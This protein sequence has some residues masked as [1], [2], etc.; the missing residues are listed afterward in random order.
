MMR[1]MSW[2]GK[3]TSSPPWYVAGLAFECTGCG[4]C[5]A[6]PA[7]GYVWVSDDEVIAIARKLGMSEGA[8]RKQYVRKVGRRFS[9]VEA[10]NRDCIFLQPAKDGVRGCGIYEVRPGQCRTWPFWQSNLGSPEAWSL[11]A[12]RCPGINRGPI[13]PFDEI[14]GKR[15][16]TRE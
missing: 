3:S 16:D 13:H 2:F 11:A 15:L 14:E 10:P 9:L 8:F 12:V 1:G 6:G 7:E 5:C 4:D